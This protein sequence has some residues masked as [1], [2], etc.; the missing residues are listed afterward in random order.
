[1]RVAVTG[2]GMVNALGNTANNV[3]RG[4][5]LQKS[6]I[7]SLPLSHEVQIGGKPNFSTSSWK[8]HVKVSNSLSL[9]YAYAA[10][11]EALLQSSLPSSAVSLIYETCVSE[12]TIF[13]LEASKLSYSLGITS[14]VDC[15]ISSLG[16]LDAVCSGINRVKTGVFDKILIVGSSAALNPYYLDQFTKLGL[17]NNRDNGNPE[18]SVKSFDLNANG[19]VLGEGAA[20]IL[21]ESWD[22][23]IE[24]KAK[25]IAEVKGHGRTNDGMFLFKP[26]EKAEGLIRA[27][28]K[29]LKSVKKEDVSAILADGISLIERDVAEAI[30]IDKLVP[31]VPT[32]SF[33]AGF[34][35]M[36]GAAGCSQICSAVLALEYV[37]VI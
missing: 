34:G 16:G 29:A 35:H 14:S 31:L 32:S 33:K 23:A 24:R 28:E 20:A 12:N 9:Y 37:R 5:S 17:L 13:A 26:H 21:L 4:L 15:K 18:G 10:A 7:T 3:W 8:Q 11:T 30:A 22:S 2:I 27:C 6:G 1:M 36:L 19:I 25:I